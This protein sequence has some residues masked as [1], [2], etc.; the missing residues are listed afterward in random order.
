MKHSARHAAIMKWSR[1]RKRHGRQDLL[2]DVAAVERAEAENAA[3]DPRRK[4][5]R[6]AAA[7]RRAA[8]DET[9]RRRFESALRGRYPRCPAAEARRIVEQACAKYSGR[10]GR[11]APAK[12]LAPET[13]DLAVGS[14]AR[15]A[16]NE[17]DRL[18]GMG[19]DRAEARR[20]VRGRVEEVIAAGRAVDVS[21]SGLFGTLVH[22][23]M[24]KPVVNRVLP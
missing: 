21:H 20:E 9:Y 7:G 17:Y 16:R 12:A 6:E 3:D 22:P 23:G 19:M 24:W 10:V 15:L 11:S 13:I 1:A 8:E 4:A 2:V 14:Y 5:R 18:I